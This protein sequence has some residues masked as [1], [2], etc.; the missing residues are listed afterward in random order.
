MGE[1]DGVDTDVPLIVFAAGL[2]TRFGG[3]KVLA[4]VGLGGEPLLAVGIGQAV[5]A[6]FT[7]IVVVTRPELR[8]AT[9]VVAAATRAAHG[10]DVVLVDQ[11]GV[12]PRR[13]KPWGTVAA[14][15]AGIPRSADDGSATPVVVANGDDLYGIEGLRQARVAAVSLVDAADPSPAAVCIAYPFASSVLGES[16]HATGASGGGVSRGLCRVDATGRLLELH[17]GRHLHPGDVEPDAPVSMNLWALG[18]RVLTELRSQFGDF[19]ATHDD[20]PD[21]ELGLPDALGALVAH[22]RLYARV[23]VTDSRWLGVTFADDVERVRAALLAPVAGAFG[24]PEPT[25]ARLVGSGHIHATVVADG[26][27]YQRINTGVF[28]DLGAL[29]DTTARVT[30]HVPARTDVGISVPRPLAAAEGGLVWHA[31]D[32]AV[33][34]ATEEIT[35]VDVTL[36]PRSAVEAGEAARAFGAFVAALADLPGPR[37]R[38]TIP[39]FHDFA[40][41]REQLDAAV[42]ADAV[43]R[44]ASCTDALAEARDLAERVAAAL[45]TAGVGELPPRIVHNDAKVAN[46]LFR[47]GHAVAVVDL[48]TVMVGTLLADL[49]ELLRTG[50]TRAREDEPDADHVTLDDERLDAIV[51]GYLDGLGGLP[52]ASELAALPLAGAWMATENGLRFLTDHLEGDRYFGADHPG[53]NLERTRTQLRLGGLLLDAAPE[54]VTIVDRCATPRDTPETSP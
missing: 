5:S 2:G 48:D 22:G 42:R 17:E 53:H 27:V 32:G 7:S 38:D 36:V 33:W 18:P 47:H 20:D 14:L 10:I 28:R 52:T 13:D 1:R 40:W 49:G 9:E 41:R 11:A 34:R 35:D 44:L 6:G 12:G 39:R 15:L 21:A 31:P 26:V 19:V 51:R 46:V 37:P 25:Q 43:G 54:I 29:T 4:P 50:A 3:P 16:E 23:V 30:V 45:A 8:E 24:R